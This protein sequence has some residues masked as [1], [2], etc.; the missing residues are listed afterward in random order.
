MI[1]R[2]D[3]LT[4]GGVAPSDLIEDHGTPLFV[5]DAGVIETRYGA[6]VDAFERAGIDIDVRYAMKANTNPTIVERLVDLGAGLDCAS[7]L[8][9]NLA[10]SLVDPERVL[11]TAPYNRGSELR[12]AVDQGVTINLDGPYLLEHL[13]VLPRE[14]CFRIDPGMGQGAHG[15]AFGG[16]ETKFGI[17]A[18]DAI[19]AYATAADRGVESFGIHMMPGS[20]VLDPAYFE[21]VTAELLDIADDIASTLDITF[22]FI[23]L[24]GGLGIPYRPDDKPLDLDAVAGGVA[25]VFEEKLPDASFGEPQVIIEPGRYLV[26]ES[27]VLLTSVTGVKQ[28]GSKTFVGVD[29]GMHHL[30]R[31]MLL[32]AYHEIVHAERPAEDPTVTADVV[33]PVCSTVDT[34]GVDRSLPAVGTGEP[35]AIMDVGAYGYTMSSQFNTRL[36]PPEIL[37]E[38]GEQRVIREGERGGD[39]FRG[40]TYNP[41]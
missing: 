18:D 8:E 12:H 35:L 19:D 14:L 26:G 21:A 24:G 29:T 16:G 1:E 10:V 22:S 27:G 9:V 41:S 6:L 2:G 28:K 15:L 17:N 11:Y 32:D 38:A 7:R 36:R 3:E 34:L 20:G 5:Y 37:T 4:I 40:T 13:E 25:D 33:G 31:P 30:L 23:D 39:L